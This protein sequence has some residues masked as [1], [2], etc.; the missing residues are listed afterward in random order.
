[1][2]WRPKRKIFPPK[3]LPTFVISYFF[4]SNME[5]NTENKDNGTMVRQIF[6]LPPTL[7][8]FAHPT[9]NFT[10]TET[11]EWLDPAWAPNPNGGNNEE[12]PE[13]VSRW[14]RLEFKIVR[15]T[16]NSVTF[17]SADFREI[18]GTMTTCGKKREVGKKRKQIKE[19]TDKTEFVAY[20][21]DQY[22]RM[23]A[24]F[25]CAGGHERYYRVHLNR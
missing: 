10:T 5:Q 13:D 1:V 2:T 4:L 12:D 9:H 3:P 6:A 15:S 16:V 8:D 17:S 18:R 19:C 22:G 7:G 20:L 11:K 23:Y 21:E 24:K 14:I 25:K